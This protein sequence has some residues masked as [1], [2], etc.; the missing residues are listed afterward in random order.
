MAVVWGG[1]SRGGIEVMSRIPFAWYPSLSSRRKSACGVKRLTGCDELIGTGS[2]GQGQDEFPEF[3]D[4]SREERN[5]LETLGGDCFQ[6][7]KL[8]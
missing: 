5:F 8:P 2:L 7:M 4:W 3:E 1:T 6:M